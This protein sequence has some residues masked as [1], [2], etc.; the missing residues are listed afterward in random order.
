MLQL[1]NE[2]LTVSIDETGAELKS[3]KD[4]KTGKEYMWKG[5]KNVWGRVSPV[6]FPFVGRTVNAKF[7][8]EGKEYPTTPHGFARDSHFTQGDISMTPYSPAKFTKEST[9]V[10]YLEDND[11]T[12]KV[13]PFKFRLIL[14]YHLSERTLT[15]RYIVNNLNDGKMYF[16]IG[17]HPGFT[18]PINENAERRDS[19]IRFTLKDKPLEKI[20]SSDIDLSTGFA[21]DDKTEYELSDGNLIIY[22]DLFKKDALVLENQQVDA[23][24]LLDE[25]KKAYVTVRFISPLVGVWSSLNKGA[26]FV[27]IEPWWGRCD[28]KNFTG[29]LEERPYGNVLEKSESFTTGFDIDFK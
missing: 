9:L 6:L 12:R 1:E 13:Y 25:N 19:F 11:E 27:C 5:D 29:T 21:T 8:F 10:L 17:G 26:D 16:S 7:S 15:L 23:I 2:F 3:V 14:L 22:D 20:V 18:C 28:H 24:S 4:K